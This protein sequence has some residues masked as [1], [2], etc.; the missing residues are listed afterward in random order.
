M[1]SQFQAVLLLMDDGQGE[2]IKPILDASQNTN[3][4]IKLLIFEDNFH[5]FLRLED[6]IGESWPNEGKIARSICRHNCDTRHRNQ[7]I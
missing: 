3:F 1:Y 4:K 7:K 6:I 5:D 2:L